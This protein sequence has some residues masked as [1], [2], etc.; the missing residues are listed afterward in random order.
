M[1]A[2][3]DRLQV[4]EPKQQDSVVA[5]QLENAPIVSMEALR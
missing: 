4:E 2:S 1:L 3:R 5:P